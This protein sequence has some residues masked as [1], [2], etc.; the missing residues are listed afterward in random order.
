MPAG[1]HTQTDPEIKLK[2]DDLVGKH[3]MDGVPYASA[4]ALGS[5][6]LPYLFE[7]LEDQS[8]KPYW[9][10]IIV[11]I[12]FIEDSSAILPLLTFLETPVDE[13]D[14]FS[15]RALL[16]IPYALGCIASNGSTQALDFL[17]EKAENPDQS[18]LRWTFRGKPIDQ[19]ISEQSVMALAVSGRPEARQVLENLQTISVKSGDKTSNAF[20]KG[21][22]V[23]QGLVLMDRIKT[24][25]RARV[26]N[27]QREE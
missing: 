17:G 18:P 27:P 12:G 15:F 10:N 24:N 26:L 16:S 6:S 13:V 8:Q 11:T 1:G 19:I 7:L 23:N 14:S 21:V 9:V 4:N 22:S 3:Y 5:Q 25:G 2:V 20:R